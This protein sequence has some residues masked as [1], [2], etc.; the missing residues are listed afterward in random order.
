MKYK[1]EHLHRLYL[2][3][4]NALDQAGFPDSSI[5]LYNKALVKFPYSYLLYFNKGITY[6]HQKI[7][8]PAIEAFQQAIRLNPFHASSHL[9]LGKICALMGHYTHAMLSLE[10][11]LIIDPNSERSNLNLVFLNN[12]VNN[13]L[14]SD[15]EKITP[16]GPNAFSEIDHVIGSGFALNEGYKM[17][18]KFNVPVAKQSQLLF[19]SLKY[20][21]NTG[22]F[23]M[24]YY[25]PLFLSAKQNNHT[26][27]FIC[28]IL[29]T[30]SDKTIAKEVSKR[31]KNIRVMNK[32]L[33]GSLSKIHTNIK[34]KDGSERLADIFLNED[35][36]MISMGKYTSDGNSK[37]GH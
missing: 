28:K 36:I 10:T 21:P 37:T 27:D 22:D 31:E 30:A 9:V 6:T 7:Y 2:I 33:S 26:D 19:E 5:M 1:S 14:G 32:V 12:F 15:Y 25:V 29:T 23:W 34:V 18:L 11:F 17:K 3:K 4:G 8:E 24:E 20:T 16:S 13:A 35:N